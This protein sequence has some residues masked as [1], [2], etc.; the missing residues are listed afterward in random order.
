MSDLTTLQKVFGW[1]A[2][3]CRNSGSPFSGLVLDQIAA[4]LA[5][6]SPYFKALE[7]WREARTKVLFDDAVPIRLLAAFHYLAL[8]G[9]APELT[10]LYPPSAAPAPEVVARAMRSAAE[11]HPQVIAGY[12]ASPPQ[13]NEV[14]RALCLVGGFLTVAAETGL[15]LRC[16]ELGASAGLNMNWDRFHY[17]FGGGAMWGDPAAAVQ[18]SGWE[19]GAPPLPD[20][21]RVTERAACD[22]NPIDVTDPEW[23]LRLQSYV[24][25]DQSL[26]LE[27]LRAAIAVKR[28]TGGVPERADA[29][30]WAERHVHPAS[31]LATV[32]YHSVF[33]QYPPPETQARIV[34][35][36]D[37][38]G[39]AATAEA[40]LAW[41]S[42][43]PVPND[44]A[45]MEV[46]LRLW[47]GGDERMLA[48]VHSHGAWV[49]WL[50]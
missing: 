34:A 18:L 39:A 42:M 4:G 20:G 13:T 46:R 5:S 8:S 47:P 23:A 36:I 31:G 11:A 21:L 50:A 24:W 29:A 2:E 49:K 10:R 19:G 48:Q 12:M 1:Q 28:E 17:T 35:A 44:A 9:M 40:P 22:Q 30:D 7:P 37:A 45:A 14:G 6:D 15:P 26:R 25:A 41:L 27:R 3:F 33:L 16:L 43:E 32:V 38:A